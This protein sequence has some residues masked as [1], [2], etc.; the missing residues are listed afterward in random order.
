MWGTGDTFDKDIV[1]NRPSDVFGNTSGTDSFGNAD[2]DVWGN[3]TTIG[4]TLSDVA[5]WFF[6]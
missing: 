2:A 3:D 1:G 6:G 4:D 5:D